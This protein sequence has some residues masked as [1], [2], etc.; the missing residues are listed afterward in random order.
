M[1]QSEKLQIHTQF[2]TKEISAL[3]SNPKTTSMGKILSFGHSS[4]IRYGISFKEY[5][6]THLE[7]FN[8][9]SL[10][11]TYGDIY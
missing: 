7:A 5:L 9:I 11:P 3:K 6:Y 8:K 10:Q 1:V 2:T 4:R